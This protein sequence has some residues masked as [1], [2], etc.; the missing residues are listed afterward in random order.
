MCEVDQRSSIFSNPA[1]AGGAARHGAA[2]RFAIQRRRDLLADGVTERELRRRL[3]C[4]DLTA[5]RRGA[6]LETAASLPTS[7]LGPPEQR[8]LAD[9]HA[10][11]PD[12]A[13]DAVVSHVSAALMYGLPVWGLTLGRLHWTRPRRSGARLG[14]V[15]HVHAAPLA[16][17]EICCVEGMVVTSIARTVVDI[18]RSESFAAAVSVADAALHRHLVTPAELTVAVARAGRRPGTPAA[19]RVVKFADARSMSVGESR[20]RIAIRDAGLPTPELQWKVVSRDGV[21]LGVVDFAWPELRTVGEFDGRVKYG[22][23]LRPGAATGR[24]DV[25]GEVSRRRHP[26]RGLADGSVDLAR[27]RR[28]HAGRR[29]PSPGVSVISH[30]GNARRTSSTVCDVR[31]R[32]ARSFSA[33]AMGTPGGRGAPRR[34]GR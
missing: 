31:S 30:I 9:L 26:R 33:A 18:G 28:L 2:M 25:R 19:A 14:T 10:V 29:A 6:Y 3:R 34:V 23:L 8:H 4:G 5:L 32:C 16:T 21:V 1:R 20:S 27:S 7:P 22:R 13:P 11:L 15:A 12:L 17:D 24:R